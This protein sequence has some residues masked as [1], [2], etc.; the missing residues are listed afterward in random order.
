M[1]E[2]APQVE[3][4][5]WLHCAPGVEIPIVVLSDQPLQ[6]NTHWQAKNP[7]ICPGVGCLSCAHGAAMGVRYMLSVWD[8]EASMRCI[9]EISAPV[10]SG[11]VDL[12][13]DPEHCRGVCLMVSREGRLKTSRYLLR[14]HGSGDQLVR[15]EFWDAL[16]D[17]N[18][19]PEAG[20][21]QGALDATARR[22]GIC[23]LVRSPGPDQL[24][25]EGVAPTG[26]EARARALR[27]PNHSLKSESGEAGCTPVSEGAV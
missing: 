13:Q 15:D 4:N 19:L 3:R 27:H 25:I 18:E 16:Y 20:D 14:L 8:F 10:A 24:A 6:F 23:D 5:L 22:C 7:K 2:T 11:L 1:S 21:L 17:R 9:L 12:L 26:Y